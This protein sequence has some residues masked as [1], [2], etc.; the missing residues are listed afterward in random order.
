MKRFRTGY[1]PDGPGRR[2]NPFHLLT[3][4][5]ST[6]I[7]AS[8][9]LFASAPPVLDQGQTGSCTGHAL[10]CSIHV[11]GKLAWVASPAEIYRNGRAID[12][13]LETPLSDDGAEPNQVF[14]AVR[15]FGVRPMVPLRDRFSDA[16]PVTV[17][18]EPKLGDLEVE[19]EAMPISDYGIFS[20]GARRSDDIALAIAAGRPVNVAIAGGSDAFQD[21]TGGVLPALHAPLDH[22]VTLLSYETLRDGSRVFGGR[23]SWGDWGEGGNFRLSEA[24]VA[25]LGDIVAVDHLSQRHR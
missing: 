6:S 19:A 20:F 4:R 15:E 23:N 8:A 10:A 13:D 9:S 25:E 14:R 3:R 18:D 17:N 12:R 2:R 16:D 22:Y 7:P 11:V 21:Y 24:A 1:I 5:I